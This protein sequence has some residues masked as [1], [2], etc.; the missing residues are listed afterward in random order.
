[1][2]FKNKFRQIKK[3]PDWFYKPIVWILLLWRATLRKELIDEEQELSDPHPPAVGVAWHNRLLF[4]PLLFPRNVRKMT[5]AVVSA[6]RDGQ[7]IA[8]LAGQMGV[9]S[10]RGSSRK[11]GFSAL[12]GVL[13][14][15]R[16]GNYVCFTPDGP[17]GPRYRMSQGPIYAASQLG[18]PIIPLAI[19]YASRW[20]LKSWD[21]FQIPKPFS[22]V[23][24][25]LG[26]RISIP[27]DLSAEE[28]EQYRLLV[29]K[30]LNEHSLS[31][32]ESAG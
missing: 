1:M 7:Y 21:R 26:K 29:E 11:K 16:E 4:L 18:V 17:R 23:T 2:S 31:D 19:N 10:V 13:R 28:L 12:H 9:R 8:D 24:L 14:E 6:S 3:L 22:R 25:H 32:G 27:P 20:E 30:R 15:I 5:C